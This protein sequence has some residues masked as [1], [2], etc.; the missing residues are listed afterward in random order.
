MGDY[1]VLDARYEKGTRRLRS[2]G[3]RGED[4]SNTTC[5]MAVGNFSS[6]PGFYHIGTKTAGDYIVFRSRSH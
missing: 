2:V 5:V 4:L 3:E 6:N 1:S